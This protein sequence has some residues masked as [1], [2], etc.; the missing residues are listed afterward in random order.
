MKRIEWTYEGKMK[1]KRYN[2][3]WSQQFYDVNKEEVDKHLWWLDEN[4][5]QYMFRNMYTDIIEWD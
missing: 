5:R 1:Y 2:G 4:E 3:M